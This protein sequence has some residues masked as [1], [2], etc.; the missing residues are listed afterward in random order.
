MEKED[1]D[2]EDPELIA[3][4]LDLEP[5]LLIMKEDGLSYKEADY[6]MTDGYED[7]RWVETIMSSRSCFSK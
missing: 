6:K 1:P 4:I 3:T 7:L 2:Y 5:T